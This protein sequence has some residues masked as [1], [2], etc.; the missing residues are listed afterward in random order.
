MENLLSYLNL[1]VILFFILS[2]INVILSTCKSILTI[3]ST[4]LNAA[5]INAISFGFY[6]IVL[7]QIQGVDIITSVLV[8]MAANFIGVYIAR[9]ILDKF[10]KDK[11]YKIEVT[12]KNKDI[13]NIIIKELNEYDISF[14]VET[15][16][17]KSGESI[18]LN[19]FSDT[20]EESKKIKNILFNKEV[21]YNVFPVMEHL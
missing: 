19:I 18:G 6:T 1:F 7:K 21:K 17:K 12:C 9:W 8:T 20:K 13:G 5:I 15:I 16:Y 14:T 3:K 4:A 11:R 2:L 10:A